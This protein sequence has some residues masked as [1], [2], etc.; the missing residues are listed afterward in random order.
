MSVWCFRT[1][2]LPKPNQM[3]CKRS[4]PPPCGSKDKEETCEK[5]IGKFV[6][7]KEAM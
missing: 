1:P 7:R 3:R 4:Q 6:S 5:I 2:Q